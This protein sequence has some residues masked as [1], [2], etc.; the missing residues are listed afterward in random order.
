MKR[1]LF[2]PVV[3]LLFLLLAWGCRPLYTPNPTNIPLFSEA[4]EGQGSLSIGSNG[5]NLQLAWAPVE[6]LGLMVNAN[7]YSVF[8]DSA[9]VRKFRHNFAEAG[10]GYWTRL[11][12]YLRQEIYVGVGGGFNGEDPLRYHYTRLFFQP[13]IGI[14]RRYIDVGFSP[15]IA[16]VTHHATETAGGRSEFADQGVF[17]EPAMTFRAGYDQI[18]FQMQIH[19]SFDLGGAAYTSQDWTVGFGIHI[20]LGKDFERYT[21]SYE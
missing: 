7:S 14:S 2:I 18:K 4:G 9:F 8:T 3:S 15:R 10:I 11:N 19:R 12:K 20:T 17:L 1:P 16:F 21:Y 6:H 13:N 5:Y